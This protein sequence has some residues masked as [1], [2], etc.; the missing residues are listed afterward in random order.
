MPKS[1]DDIIRELPP[2]R[3]ERVE[4]RAKQL[5]AI[6]MKLRELREQRGMTQEA[7]ADKLGI[8]QDSVSRLEQ[9]SDVRIST[10]R[11][12]VEAMGGSLKLVAE[13]PGHPPVVLSGFGQ[14]AARAHAYAARA[15]RDQEGK[16]GKGG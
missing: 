5:I 1:L 3:R 4:A 12:T 11:K 8:T 13:F 7:L 15:S 14:S 6:E 16:A 2:K 10:L 9:R